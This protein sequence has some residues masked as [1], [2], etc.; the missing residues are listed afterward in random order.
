MNQEIY[1]HRYQMYNKELSTGWVMVCPKDDAWSHQNLYEIM[2]VCEQIETLKGVQIQNKL[3]DQTNAGHELSYGIGWNATTDSRRLQEKAL[4]KKW[5][6]RYDRVVNS[7]PVYREFLEASPYI[8]M[9]FHFDNLAT[10]GHLIAD[11]KTELPRLKNFKETRGM[12]QMIHMLG[13]TVKNQ[14]VRCMLFKA[15][16]CLPL[17]MFTAFIKVLADLGHTIVSTLGFKM[18]LDT[19]ATLEVSKKKTFHYISPNQAREIDLKSE[20]ARARRPYE[21][22]QKK[23]EA[24]R[25]IQS[26]F[27]EAISNPNYEMCRS[28]LMR[29]YEEHTKE[30][31]ALWS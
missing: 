26:A 16:E 28:R 21:L 5:K 1:C 11:W 19:G 6:T 3:P 18:D 8:S 10:G 22:L 20:Q 23:N 7:H 27:K 13:H 2:T 12:D 31:A 25:K 9:E 17:S 24:A 4:R 15:D 14:Y 29:E 30:L